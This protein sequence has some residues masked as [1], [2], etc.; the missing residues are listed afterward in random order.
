MLRRVAVLL[1]LLA[2]SGGALFAAR[3]L[4]IPLPWDFAATDPEPP[5]KDREASPA[6]GAEEPAKSAAEK[7]IED[8]TAALAPQEPAPAQPGSVSIDISRISPDGTSVIAGHAEPDSY[9]TVLE[10]GKPAGTAKTDSGGNWSLATEHRFAST[11]PKLSYEVRRTPPPEP[12][13]PDA[14]VA[15]KEPAR[16]SQQAN[17]AGEVMRKFESLVEEAR[18]EAK[19]NEAEA[20]KAE[21]ETERAEEPAKAS[22]ELQESATT[23]APRTPEPPAAAVTEAPEREPEAREEVTVAPEPQPDQPSGASD[24]EPAPSAEAKVALAPQESE[25]VKQTVIPVPIMFVYNESRLTPDGERAAGLLL[26]YLKLKKLSAVELT[27]H[28]DERGSDAYNFDLSRERL[29]AVAALLKEGGYTGDLKLTPK[30]KTEPYMGVNRS[31]YT[32][33]ALFQLDRRV[34]LRLG[35]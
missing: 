26:E 7:A 10:E 15:A 24:V 33:E 8:T 6:K 19:K 14:Q 29:D 20:K 11:D 4:G 23:E 30:G 13:K 2:I 32:G 31:A 35:R 34:E 27:G 16:P 3:H 22:D 1:I 21:E 9:V 28:A 5:S 17:A 18:E 25:P 12:A